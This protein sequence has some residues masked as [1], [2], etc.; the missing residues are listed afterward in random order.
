MEKKKHKKMRIISKAS[1]F[2]FFQIIFILFTGPTLIFCGPFA[3][4]KSIVA[5]S[6]YTSSSFTWLTKMYMSDKS[7]A[8]MMSSGDAKNSYIN[9]DKNIVKIKKNKSNT[10]DLFEVKARKFQGLAMVVDDPTRVKVG[11]TD[12]LKKE[13]QSTSEIAKLND[14]EAAINGGGFFTKDTTEVVWTG[15]GGAPKGMI[16]SKGE[17]I[18]SDTRDLDYKQDVTAFTDK[19]ELLVGYYSYNELVKKNVKEAICFGPALIIN[20]KKTALGDHGGW[21]IAPRSAV[22]QKK[23]GSMVMLVL[24]GRKL[25]SVGATLE[26]VQ[27]IMLKLGVVNAT[28]LDGGYSTTMY[29]KGQV[30]NKPYNILGERAVPSILYVEKKK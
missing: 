8:K 16:V 7:I 14:A 26:D 1:I 9:N 13:G 15:A 2:I 24:E 29:Y 19:G 18:F 20:G 10:I 23:D 11:Y 5:Q 22:G 6:A 4:L 25:D 3:N 21:G 12:K 28:N 17:L 27:D 30:I